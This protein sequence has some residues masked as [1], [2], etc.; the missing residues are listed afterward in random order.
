MRRIKK[1]IAE[2]TKRFELLI[3]IKINILEK[4]PKNG[5]TPAIESRAIVIDRLT[6]VSNPV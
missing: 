2:K 1:N 4:N 5:G 3:I 6:V